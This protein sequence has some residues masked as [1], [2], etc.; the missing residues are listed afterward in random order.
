MVDLFELIKL[1]VEFAKSANTSIPG[2]ILVNIDYLLILRTGGMKKSYELWE[3]MQ[4]GLKTWQSFKDHLSLTYRQY[5]ILKK[6]T[7]AAHGYG[8]SANNTQEIYSEVNTEDVLQ[9][10]VCT[11][12]E[13]N[14]AISNLASINLTLSQSLTKSQE[15]NIVLSKHL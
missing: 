7:A 5:Q 10:L 6:A 9:S 8:A 14:E 13:D 12:M 15:T 11:A 2:E 4:V 3:D 1:G